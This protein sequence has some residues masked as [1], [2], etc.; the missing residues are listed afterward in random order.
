MEIQNKI[1]EQVF[2][3]LRS[4][5]SQIT[6]GDAEGNATQDPAEAVFFNFNYEDK[7]GHNHGNITI[8]LI[9]QSMKVYYSKNISKDLTGSELS[10][11]YAFLQDLRKTAMSNLYRF[12]THDISKSA[13]DIT[14]IQS[15][16]NRSSMQESKMYGSTKSSYQECGPAKIIVRH[17]QKIDP[18]VRGARSRKVESVFVETAEGERFKMPFNSLPG[19]RAMAQ[20]IGQGGR[21][22]DE[23][24]ES[25]ETM[26]NEIAG[27][28]P[29]IARNRNTVFEDETTMAMVEAAK[30]YYNE[31]RSTLGKLKG[32]RGYKAYVESFEVTETE[33]ILEDDIIEIKDRFTK[34][35][36]SDKMEAAMP[37]VQ[38]AYS[39]KNSNPSAPKG[40][41][42]KP[43][44]EFEDWANEITEMPV[45][46]SCRD[47]LSDEE[48][49]EVLY[50]LSGKYDSLSDELL[51]KLYR[52]YADNGEM[53]YDV[54]KDDP[55]EW[56]WNHLSDEYRSE[57]PEAKEELCPE[58]CCGKPV[59]QCHC[60]P[61]C[62]HC[63]CHAKNNKEQ[64][65]EVKSG[66][67]NSKA[68]GKT[69]KITRSDDNGNKEHIGK[70][71]TIVSA[72]R[73]HTFSAMV[74]FKVLY[75]VEL[76][77]G[78]IIWIRRE[79]V[80]PVKE[81]PVTEGTWAIPDTPEKM[82][83][84]R[85]ILSGELTFGPNADNALNAVYGLFGD[86]D[87]ADAI[88]EEYLRRGPEADAT[89]VI[90]DWIK[91]NAPEFAVGITEAIMLES[92]ELTDNITSMLLNR[93]ARY[94]PEVF[95]RHG[96]EY[97]YNVVRDNVSWITDEWPEDEGFGSSDSY[98][99]WKSTMED[100]GID[101]EEYRASVDKHMK[102]LAGPAEVPE[103]RGRAQHERMKSG[104]VVLRKATYSDY[105]EVYKS[106][107]VGGT[108]EDD[109]AKRM[110]AALKKQGKEADHKAAKGALKRMAEQAA[111]NGFHM[112]EGLN[113][114]EKLLRDSGIKK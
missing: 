65:D 80:R 33:E 49:Q 107:A 57:I 46:E 2:D 84:L 98:G 58:E 72:E 114:L 112:N 93:I 28:R 69:V 43:I 21:P 9:D 17:A 113:E 51:D 99:A 97:V 89:G 37:I 22:Y 92:E 88:Y 87:L 105:L 39:L 104:D 111:K 48:L 5:F 25:I 41:S 103:S 71:G 85:D 76:D 91:D 14:D 31:T 19:T 64:V 74:P 18:E 13:L 47:I 62:P 12:D 101:E 53:P 29:F 90:K 3:K 34:K 7:A 63:D 94:V 23:I 68:I 79:G 95:S 86:D 15:T 32:K 8:S 81:Q 60:G 102:G 77:D 73:E 100:L 109:D 106:S 16:V 45:N 42:M 78:E 20:H 108:D 24:G 40:P 38:K 1:S 59:S 83:Q 67:F 44:N 110:V 56:L 6:L 75:R 35:R 10:E 50:W 61:E 26:V 36:F 54:G 70:T 11:W 82:A 66:P 4:K 96:P 55:T 52:H 30:E 27:L